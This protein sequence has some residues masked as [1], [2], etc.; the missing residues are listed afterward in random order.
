MADSD[1]WRDL[2]EKFRTLDST[3]LLRADWHQRFAPESLQPHEAKWR[4]IAIGPSG[5]STRYEFEALA[6]R[7]GREIHPKWESLVL[8]RS[9]LRELGMHTQEGPMA[10][11]TRPDGTAVWHIYS[12]SVA[13]PCQA[14]V[15]CCKH[16]ESIA[17]ETER[18]ASLQ[19]Q[20]K[21]DPQNWSPLRR[22]VEAH[23]ATKEMLSKPLEEIPEALVR[24]ALAQQYGI[25]PEE[26][27]WELIAFEVSGLL[28]Q[29]P[30][31]RVVPTK[32]SNPSPAA[33]TPPDSDPAVP[34][35]V[36]PKPEPLIDTTGSGSELHRDPAAEERTAL[37][38]A[39]KAKGREH[40]IK[41]TDEM[42]AGAAKPG[43]WNTRTPVTR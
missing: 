13:Q 28:P 17:L 42:V 29:Y 12:G 19:D 39:F 22:Y 3:V 10:I 20:Q 33:P 38:L 21:A 25:S 16:Y 36:P 31:I 4:I 2:A 5:R 6:R 34:K 7:G 43:R 27:S 32:P 26:V 37:L 41:I 30:A 24:E 8:F 1:F 23:K 9:A 18:M 11:E 15:D 40:G 35:D 14:S